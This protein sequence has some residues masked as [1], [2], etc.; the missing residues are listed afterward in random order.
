MNSFDRLPPG[1]LDCLFPRACLVSGKPLKEVHPYRYLC[2]EEG[3]RI[4]H[5]RAP[6]CRTCGHPFWGAVAEDQTCPHCLEL[7]PAFGEG[8]TATLMQGPARVLIHELK[9]RRGLYVIP[10][11]VNLARRSKGFLDFLEGGCLV[12]VPLHRRRRS[13]RGFNQSL[14][15]ARAVSK[16]VCGCGLAELLVRTRYTRTQTR[17]RRSERQDNMRGAFRMRRGIVPDPDVRYVLF[18]DVFTTGATLN[19]CARVLKGAG[20]ERVDIATFCH[21]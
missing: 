11:L 15:L 2:A 16:E 7:R 1:F 13:Q 3:E 5:V 18:D 19:A 14:E 20:A 10:D 21:G 8:K 4:L 9:Y 12:P 17:L 6:H